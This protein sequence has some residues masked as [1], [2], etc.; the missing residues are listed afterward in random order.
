M[1]P[2]RKKKGKFKLSIPR[3]L[4][5]KG[6]AVFLF[7]L[8]LWACTAL[9]FVHHPRAWLEAHCASWP[10]LVTV[11]LLWMGEPLGDVTDAVG[12]TGEDAVET[13][14]R[15]AP[16]DSVLFAGLPVRKS[17]PAPKDIIVL[18]RGEFK[19]GWSP[20]LRH[21]VWVAYHVPA[22]A[23]SEAGK[24]P[25]FK[26]DREAPNSPTAANYAKTGYDRGH[27]A[28]N[29]AI[30]TRFG[31]EAQNRTFLMSNVSPQTPRLNR[32]VWRDIEHRIA[33]LWTR[34]WGEIWVIVGC[35]SDGHWK[36]KETDIDIP[37]RFYQ[38]V[39]AQEGREIRA[40]AMLIEQNVPWKAWPTRYL[41][42]IDELEELTGFDFLPDLEDETEDAL[43]AKLPSRLW[44][45]RFGDVL[46]LIRL[47]SSGH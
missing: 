8:L 36:L 4:A 28:P 30:A 45:I 32:G 29:Y 20:R 24:R 25:G 3:S 22:E 21:P 27:M 38:I 40:M 14:D 9:W 41:V 13:T 37:T 33:E 7:I 17:F 6:G 15:P 31:S 44:P 18:D 26:Q 2:S 5:L 35:I 39:V 23:V 19:V 42:S 1:K 10:R 46:D 16:S 12:L 11:P 43:E 47:R 34:R